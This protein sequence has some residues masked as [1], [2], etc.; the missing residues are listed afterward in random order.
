MANIPYKKI[1]NEDG[2]LLNPIPHGKIYLNE[3]PGKRARKRIERQRLFESKSK[4]T[5]YK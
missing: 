3:V 4:L 5:K 2:T 1:Y